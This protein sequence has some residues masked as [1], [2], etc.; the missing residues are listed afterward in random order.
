MFAAS[1]G[2]P[3]VFEAQQAEQGN[4]TALD[5]QR[6]MTNGWQLLLAEIPS[7]FDR[8]T[9]AAAPGVPVAGASGETSAT[10]LPAA[11]GAPGETIATLSRPAAG[12]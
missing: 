3:S 11:T 1:T 2:T 5:A 9:V 4:P 12:S 8:V 7:G 10:T 6:A